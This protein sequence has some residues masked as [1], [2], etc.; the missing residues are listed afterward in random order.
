MEMATRWLLHHGHCVTYRAGMCCG[1]GLFSTG[2]SG[3]PRDPPD[4]LPS[5]AELLVW[6]SPPH[7][8]P[9]SPTLGPG[10]QATPGTPATLGPGG[11][12]CLL[13]TDWHGRLLADALRRNLLVF[14]G[15]GAGGGLLRN[16]K[17]ASWVGGLGVGPTLD[18]R[19]RGLSA[20]PAV[21]TLRRRLHSRL[22]GQTP[23]EPLRRAPPGPLTQ[24]HVRP[25]ILLE[26]LS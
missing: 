12:P 8:T 1:T 25:G 13:K 3:G 4:P 24:F 9:E 21:S 2:P 18:S 6:C 26:P 5:A 11:G 19:S 22:G 20:Q 17:L 14:G 10:L 16:R 23:S 7:P 15:V